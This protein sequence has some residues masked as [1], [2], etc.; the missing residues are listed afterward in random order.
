MYDPNVVHIIECNYMSL[1]SCTICLFIFVFV[2]NMTISVWTEWKIICSLTAKTL[3][4][5]CSLRIWEN[6]VEGQ[7]NR[8]WRKTLQSEADC[9]G[10]KKYIYSL[11]LMT[12]LFQVPN[13]D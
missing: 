6:G 5:R 8:E 2:G 13:D 4:S 7:K 1:I 3:R 12:L 11:R 10:N 9:K